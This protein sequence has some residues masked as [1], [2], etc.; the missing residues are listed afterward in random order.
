M[1]EKTG[2]KKPGIRDPRTFMG[3]DKNTHLLGTTLRREK[4]IKEHEEK[5][6]AHETN[7]EN[8]P[9]LCQN[10]TEQQKQLWRCPASKPSLHVGRK[11]RPGHLSDLLKFIVRVSDRIKVR[12]LHF[13]LPTCFAKLKEE[14]L[15]ALKIR[16]FSK[17]FSRSYFQS[18]SVFELKFL[19]F[20][21]FWM[22]IQEKGY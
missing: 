21:R 13:W 18:F 15:A 5:I 19:F 10:E 11:H 4:K 6:R 17:G 2:T 12:D 8:C 20:W 14:E 7:S 16:I 3:Q 9:F 22:F 1:S